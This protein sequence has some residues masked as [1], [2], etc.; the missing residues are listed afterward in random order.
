VIVGKQ[1]LRRPDFGGFRVTRH[2]KDRGGTNFGWL[3]YNYGVRTFDL[4]VM[5]TEREA[6][7]LVVGLNAAMQVPQ[8]ENAT[9]HMT[10]AQL[11]Q[12]RTTDF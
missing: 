6:N 3:G 10:A 12:T 11:R 5:L 1:K 8:G 9:P 7:E 2:T 4:P